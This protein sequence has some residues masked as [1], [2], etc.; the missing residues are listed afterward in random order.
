MDG[1]TIPYDVFRV[2]NP[3]SRINNSEFCAYQLPDGEVGILTK[4][5][6][7]SYISFESKEKADIF[8]REIKG[9]AGGEL[10]ELNPQEYPVNLTSFVSFEDRRVEVSKPQDRVKKEET[11]DTQIQHSKSIEQDSIRSKDR[12]ITKDSNNNRPGQ[13]QDDL[14]GAQSQQSNNEFDGPVPF[15]P[16]TISTLP[17]E[18]RYK[19]LSKSDLEE[20][21]NAEMLSPERSWRKQISR[22][23]QGSKD[24]DDE[25]AFVDALSLAPGLGEILDIAQIPI[26]AIKDPSRITAGRVAMALL[27]FGM[28]HV[29][30]VRGALRKTKRN[31]TGKKTSPKA[32]R[33]RRLK[34]Q[35][36]ELENSTA[37]KTLKKRTDIQVHPIKKSRG[38]WFQKWLTGKD[39]EYVVKL[40]KPFVRPDGEISNTVQIDDFILAANKKV[41]IIEAKFMGKYTEI[42][43]SGHFKFWE[44]KVDHLKRLVQYYTENKDIVSHIE[45]TASRD[46]AAQIYAEII[47]RAPELENYIGTVFTFGLP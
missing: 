39:F 26:L 19:I 17:S 15:E 43:E 31:R 30:I 11:S 28:G 25:E 1:I 46:E 34:K 2:D 7:Q 32:A 36:K 45:I 18:L 10:V 38:S 47:A 37:Y 14:S 29:R 22:A 13:F 35:L 24:P 8:L 16:P 12:A 6:G 41:T 21:R 27:P 20:I 44:E 3:D 33:K 40:K 9:Q 23:L 42:S 5:F 4:N